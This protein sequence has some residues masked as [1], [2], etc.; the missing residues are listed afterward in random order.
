MIKLKES[1]N[2]NDVAIFYRG[3]EI[4]R[5]SFTRALTITVKDYIIRDKAFRS[6][7]VD[8]C[9]YNTF[10][11]TVEKLYANNLNIGG[12]M[13]LTST[14]ILNNELEELINELGARKQVMSNSGIM[15]A[16]SLMLEKTR[17]YQPDKVLGV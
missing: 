4:Y 8:Y 14:R 15:F 17:E 5:G 9:N 7:V 10:T 11:N 13:Q 12:Y 16:P 2:G 1:Y 6:D 3:K